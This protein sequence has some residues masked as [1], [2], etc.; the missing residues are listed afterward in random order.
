MKMAQTQTI[1]SELVEIEKQIESLRRDRETVSI[2][3]ENGL[4]LGQD[5][6]KARANIDKVSSTIEIAEAKR[7]G[8]LRRRVLEERDAL[9][10]ELAA[11]EM[12]AQSSANAYTE[13]QIKTHRLR[14]ELLAAENDFIRADHAKYMFHARRGGVRDRLAAFERQYTDEIA[15][16]EKLAGNEA[17]P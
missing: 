2:E 14:D 16:A 5:S 11:A 8:L 9:V 17:N 12:N 7:R 1:A 10:G 15:L 4:A 13:L 6:A 3:F